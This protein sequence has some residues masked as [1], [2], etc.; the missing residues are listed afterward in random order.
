MLVSIHCLWKKS[1]TLPNWR[2]ICINTAKGPVMLLLCETQRH[3]IGIGTYSSSG[4]R[5]EEAQSV[6][7]LWLHSD[8]PILGSSLASWSYSSGHFYLQWNTALRI[9]NEF[10]T[11]NTKSLYLVA[12]I[13]VFAIFHAQWAIYSRNKKFEFNFT[14]DHI[15]SVSNIVFASVTHTNLNLPAHSVWKVT[16]FV[17][18]SLWHFQD[19]QLLMTSR[20]IKA[21]ICNL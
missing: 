12:K 7:N 21:M 18:L 6:L 5:T 2:S 14:A 20:K 8:L 10:K 19:N 13:W 16:M 11:H 17:S 4:N 3:T 9:K 1:L 15:T